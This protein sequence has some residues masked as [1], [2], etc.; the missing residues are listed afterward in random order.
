MPH[1]SENAAAVLTVSKQVSAGR[2]SLWRW[3]A[4]TE[5]DGGEAPGGTI[6]EN[7]ENRRLREDV[8][9]LKAA[10]TFFVEE[11]APRNGWWSP[12]STSNGH[13]TVLTDRVDGCIAGHRAEIRPV[14]PS[15]TTRCKSPP[16]AAH[17][18][19]LA[20]RVE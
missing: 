10:T 8:A 5:I 15:A 7:E 1:L 6:E 16:R 3:G 13:L 9:I 20:A 4:Q 2:R 18:G 19:G 12:S 17:P 14:P 11:L